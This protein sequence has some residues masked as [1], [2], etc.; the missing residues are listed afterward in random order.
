[1]K[2]LQAQDPVASLRQ[3]T[4][5]ACRG[6]RADAE[7]VSGVMATSHAGASGP[8]TVTGKRHTVMLATGAGP[9][10]F[11]AQP[12]RDVARSRR[13][14]LSVEE[15]ADYLGLSAGTM[16]NWI[17][18]RRIEHIKVG[19]LTRIPQSALDRYILT[20]TVRAEGDS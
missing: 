14:L 9:G 11:S 20:H 5:E 15:A 3:P 6:S 18:M 19:R 1:M 8:A 4:E 7:S 10:T 16:R 2:P 17:S 13:V 12:S